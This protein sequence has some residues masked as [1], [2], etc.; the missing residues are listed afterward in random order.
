MLPPSEEPS[1]SPSL[2]PSISFSPSSI[3]S[4]VP[5]LKPSTFPSETPSNNFFSNSPTVDCK[6]DVNFLLNKNKRLTCDWIG[7]RKT[8]YRCN[9]MNKFTNLPASFYCPATCNPDCRATQSPTVSPTFQPS[10]KSPCEDMDGFKYNDS[11]KKDCNWVSAAPT[12]RC[13][14]KDKF[15]GLRAKDACPSTCNRR[16][17]CRN[18]KVTFK[19]RGK[20][21]TCKTVRKKQCNLKVTKKRVVADLCPRKCQDCYKL[22]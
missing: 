18:S 3:P 1:S 12:K 22:K 11:S 19:V 6:D 7:R 20:P 2:P 8:D 14:K 21:K 4:S 16:C 15:T 10:I 13:R 5:S 17:T 9:L